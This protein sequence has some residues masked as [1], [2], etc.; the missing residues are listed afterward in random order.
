M[1][2]LLDSIR[3]LVR[4][5]A[6]RITAHGHKELVKDGILI[7]T[8]LAGIDDAI[9]IEEYPDYY[10]GPAVLVLQLD[11]DRR[12]LHVLWGTP[13]SGEET[14]YLITAYRPDPLKWQDGFLKRRPK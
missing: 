3:A 6:Y 8:A 14:A 11:E 12:P 5:G 7:E 4:S 2:S 13:K 1:S 9:A 10:A